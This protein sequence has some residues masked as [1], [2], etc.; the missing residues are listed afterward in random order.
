MAKRLQ[1]ALFLSLLMVVMPLTPL[2][3]L[4][5]V[6]ASPEQ[7]AT[8][9]P[10]DISLLG[11]GILSEP[12]IAGDADSNFQV[13]WVENQTKLMLAT[14]DSDGLISAG[15]QPVSIAGNG[16]K[17]SP[18][19]E[20]DDAG[21]LH[22]LWIRDTSS[23]DCLVY[24]ASN[25]SSDDP[26][27]GFYNPTEY[28]LNNV[29]CKTN[30]ITENI[31]NPNLA[32][33]S[34]GAAHVV[35]QDKDDP[36]DTR[37]FLPGIR[38]SMMV[39]N[40]STNTANSPIFDTL[41]TPLASKSTFPEVT[42]TDADEVVVTWQD[43]RGSMVELSVLIGSSTGMV[44]EWTDIC[45]L[46][47]GGTDRQGWT[48]PGLRPMAN[49]AG[50]TLLETIYGLGDYIRPQANT[51]NCAGHNTN[52]RS[53]SSPLTPQFPSGGIR[54]VHRTMYNGQSQ[55][56]GV[57]WEDWGPA[58]TWA[59]LS[60]M[61]ANGNTGNA[62]NPPTQYDHRWNLDAT[63]IVI[64]IGD[65]GPKGG[66][67]A[68]QSDDIQSINEAHDACV[69]GGV[70]VMPIIGEIQSSE[71]NNMFDHA[72][73]MAQCE[74]S[75]LST[76]ARTCSG[77]NTRTTDAG[78]Y[79]G[80]WVTGNQD[81]SDSFDGWMNILHSGAPEV[82]TTV[83]DP[84]AKLNDPNHVKGT[85]A[86]E[87][88]SGD[89]VEDIGWGG[90]NGNHFVVV[91]DTR[92]TSDYSFTSKP[93]MEIASNG[94]Y[95]YIW[96]DSLGGRA[97]S[98]SQ[99]LH[100]V[101]VD[102]SN[103]NFD[104]QADGINLLL[105][106]AVP[107]S[108]IDSNGAVGS[109]DASAQSGQAAF[110]IDDDD[111][112]HVVWVES[113]WILE[114][115]LTYRRSRDATIPPGQVV[116]NAWEVGCS[117]G[118][119][120][121]SCPT[122]S[123]NLTSWDSEKM[124]TGGQPVI[125][126]VEEDF[127]SPPAL[128]VTSDSRRT[129]AVVW[130]DSEPCDNGQIGL[131]GV[132][133][134]CIRRIQRSLLQMDSN[135]PS[136]RRT[137][138]PGDV[139]TYNITIE[140]LGETNGLDMTVNLN[141]TGLPTTWEVS[142]IVGESQTSTLLSPIDTDWQ[143]QSGG[144][145]WLTLTIRAPT[146]LDAT[147]SE[148]HS[149]TLS[150]MSDDGEHGSYL[151]LELD[152]QVIHGLVISAPQ[153]E[154]EIE[155][156]GSGILSVNVSN[157]GNLW[158]EVSFPSTT[159]VDGR[160]IWGLPFGWQVSFVDHINMLADDN[161]ISKTLQIS[162]PEFQEP[163]QTNITIVGTS[164][165]VANP[166]SVPGS[167][168]AYELTINV[169]R[170]RAGNIVFELWDSQEEVGPGECGSFS[171][172]VTKHFGNDDVV[173]TVEDGPVDRP[174]SVSEE[175][176][177]EDHWILNI[178]YS[179]L[180]GGNTVAPDAR[181]YFT[182]G[183][184]RTIEVELC[185]PLQALA[186]EMEEVKLR[187]ELFVDSAAFDEISMQVSVLPMESLSAEWLNAP[188]RIEPGQAFEVSINVE[189]DGNVPQTFDPRMVDALSDWSIE[190][191]AGTATG[192]QVGDE[193]VMVAIVYVPLN[194]LA[195]DTNVVIELHSISDQ[196]S[197]RAE[198]SGQIEILPRI[199][200]KL[201]IEDEPIDNSYDLRPGDVI[202]ISFTVENSGNIAE[203]PWIENHSTG[204][205]GLLSQNPRMD[206]LEG[207]V[208]TWYVVENA[209]TPLALFTQISTEE[210]GRLKLPLLNPGDSV[211]VVLRLSMKDY[212]DWSSDYFG[213]RVRSVSGY[214]NQG[215]D[216][217]ADEQWL[218]ADSNEQIITLNAYAPDVYIFSVSEEMD[219][220]EVK[221]TIQIQNSGNDRVENIL[222]RVCGISLEVAESSGCDHNDAVAE[223]RIIFIDSAEQNKPKSHVVTVNLKES[224]SIIV[225]S[226]DADNEVIES[227]E[228][229]N[230]Q[231]REMLLQAGSDT[232]ADSI[233]DLASSNILLALMGTLW[234]VIILLG[235]SA[236][237]GR[238]QS[239]RN[240]HS[241]M[242]DEGN[243]GNDGAKKKKSKRRKSKP[244]TE[245]AYA[246][247]HSMDMSTTPQSS[248]D[249]SDLDLAPS[250]PTPDSA[251][252]G[253]LEPLGDI[254][255]DPTEEEAKS[256]DFT[257]GDLLDGLL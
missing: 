129:A 27:D 81:L 185:A 53:Q 225:V 160:T 42:I 177:R 158:E 25:F 102:L 82:W 112:M 93:K 72:Y 239:R 233:L 199:D 126:D 73:D 50:V 246:E 221:L 12:A 216:I 107:L 162:V 180:P 52:S 204:S 76:S 36:L 3:N 170:K 121:N 202:D 75:S 228:L 133:Y 145:K 63:K 247:V 142:A 167:Q 86:H 230:M 98:N 191:V 240:M 24:F 238:R 32:I 253:A 201:L 155:Q 166:A 184:A 132:E 62:A 134:L 95:Q 195:G 44:N 78:G 100:W 220:D 242:R 164:E 89:Y 92:I 74:A 60:W 56:W 217:D 211:P 210:D 41:L 79:V 219:G 249:V 196:S 149:P 6:Q 13:L 38:Y 23:N 33:D 11:M 111:L 80:D 120:S 103:F 55:N 29:V 203:S 49:S 122:P 224:I 137:L 85:P 109:R 212:P 4:D 214:S 236:V 235:I 43:S 248:L 48:S 215:G 208:S 21:T 159:S 130:V 205:G 70:V 241:S 28:S 114:T 178:D 176:W 37:F 99:E 18:R 57:Q 83:L 255:Y 14:I 222:L 171:V 193:L 31:A 108:P 97:P 256:D 147:A 68:Q 138:E 87:T 2:T 115:N 232:G 153:Q 45:T 209:G 200:L 117:D 96:T 157:Y 169:A 165:K 143:I 223:L 243:W 229:N 113:D 5:T 110:A 154:I 94:M 17:W 51:G 161:T 123:Y 174:D 245:L 88:S 198:V 84:Y 7:N 91:N 188:A 181:R 175:V 128:A 186:G 34:Q 59:C 46:M 252:S 77:A 251:P 61:D 116:T 144:S 65:E 244:S 30:I 250:D 148:S 39:A 125:F 179:G 10:L 257:I 35:W 183:M 218:T 58:T 254:G 150:I 187:G 40:W 64:P 16:I 124:G 106:Q 8:A 194:A 9:S 168:A 227:D 152:L 127:G 163:G 173:L 226:I 151:D 22:M 207:I 20:I 146:K 213:I 19:I 136:L 231:E 66:N 26:T 190:W 47:Y 139:T 197:Y 15:P 71:T 131:G 206:G 182:D 172:H 118:D 69:N 156:G 54:K 135:D 192:L 105:N 101:Q 237:R 234:I 104:G 140:H 189:N 90:S 67:P 1:L 119:Q 141:W